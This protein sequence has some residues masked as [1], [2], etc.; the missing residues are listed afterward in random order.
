MFWIG[1][2]YAQITSY[3]NWHINLGALLTLIYFWMCFFFRLKFVQILNSLAGKCQRWRNISVPEAC[4]S[5]E[6]F[7]SRFPANGE[8][9]CQWKNLP[10]YIQIPSGPASI[11]RWWFPVFDEWPQVYNLGTC[12]QNRYIL[13]FWEISHYTRRKSLETLQ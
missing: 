6:W 11:S 3:T 9:G 10:P 8:S 7:C 5:W 4:P 2:N 13:E 12:Y 1:L